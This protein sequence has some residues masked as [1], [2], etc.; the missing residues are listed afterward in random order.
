M[1]AVHIVV[2]AEDAEILSA[3]HHTLQVGEGLNVSALSDSHAVF[4]LLTEVRP[5]LIL[6]DREVICKEGIGLPVKMHRVS[7]APVLL[8]TRSDKIPILV[9]NQTWENG[10]ISRIRRALA[11]GGIQ[12]TSLSVIL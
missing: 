3:V 2:V 9:K 11:S 4:H 1:S 12:A 7:S 8:L 5:D 10:L 6:I